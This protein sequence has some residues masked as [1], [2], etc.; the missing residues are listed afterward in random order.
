MGDTV[1][2]MGLACAE[3]V[4]RFTERCSFYH[5]CEGDGGVPAGFDDKAFMAVRV[6]PRR[7]GEY[8][9]GGTAEFGVEV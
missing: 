5:V 7:D 2:A 4:N 3:R 1:G 6:F 8:G 9:W